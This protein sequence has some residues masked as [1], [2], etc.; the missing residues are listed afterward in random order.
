MRAVQ[1]AETGGPQVLKAIEVPDPVP[2]TGQ[3]LLNVVTAGVTFADTL[4]RAGSFPAPLV[5]PA[6]L[7]RE[8][9]GTVAGH[10]EGVDDPPIGARVAAMIPSGGYAERV[11]V[12]TERVVRVPD[13]VGDAQALG[14]VGSGLIAHGVVAAGRISRDDV[15]LVAAAG[16]A[17]GSLAVQLAARGGGRVIGLASTQAKRE[18][19]L[20][21]GAAAAF[22]STDDW[23]SQLSAETRGR[24]VDVVLDSVGGPVLAAG[25]RLLATYGRHVL[26]GFASGALGTVDA[27]QLGAILR[28]NLSL[29]GF[30]L[31][32]SDEAAV[33]ERIAELMALVVDGLLHVPTSDGYPLTDAPEA[34][35][36]LTERRTAGK[37]VLIV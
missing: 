3:V 2:T 13:G 28:G 25:L 26:Y 6:I 19:I 22:D 10:G 20:S 23:E 34:H 11:A 32:P 35:R 18:L 5:L 7:G 8:V 37:V 29:T 33:H 16:G 17:V 30:N 15:V 27:A 21:L 9:V 14:V 4:I 24:G 36:A 12:R 31:D 1:I